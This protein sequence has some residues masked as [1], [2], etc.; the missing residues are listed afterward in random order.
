MYP[1]FSITE[2][3]RP[4]CYLNAKQSKYLLTAYQCDIYMGKMSW[5][6][7]FLSSVCN[8]TINFVQNIAKGLNAS[9]TENYKEITAKKTV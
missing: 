7:H 9:T 3:S 2:I 5:L 6:I 4:I 8:W 1:S